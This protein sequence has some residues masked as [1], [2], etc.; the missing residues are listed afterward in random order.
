MQRAEQLRQVSEAG[1]LIRLRQGPDRLGLE[2][3]LREVELDQVDRLLRRDAPPLVCDDLL[4]DGDRAEAEVEAESALAYA[5]LDDLRLRFLLR[6][7]VPVA[8]ERC[9]ER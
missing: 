8:V 7:R 2:L 5:L 3:R 9:D 4:R 1:E 6:H